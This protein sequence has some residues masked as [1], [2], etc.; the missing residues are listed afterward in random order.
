M[1]GTDPKNKAFASVG[2]GTLEARIEAFVDACRR[3]NLRVTHQRME[4]YRELAAT[5]EHPDV[6]TIYRRVRRR[7]PM[8]SLDT[9]Y[10]NLKLLAEKG[11]ISVVG[12]SEE[13]LRFDA[14]IAPHHHFVCVSCGAIRDFTSPVLA[15]LRLPAGAKRLGKPLSVHLEV[16]GVCGACEPKG[17]KESH[18]K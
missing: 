17:G 4:I 7:I 5:E 2:P 11:L 15:N 18:P 12:L 8:I 1:I 3:Q 13:R 16:K 9:V 6:D 10:R 14:N